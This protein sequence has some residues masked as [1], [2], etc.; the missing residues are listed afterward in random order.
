MLTG[1]DEHVVS[2]VFSMYHSST[3]I[4]S[5][6][7]PLVLRYCSVNFNSMRKC[8]YASFITNYL[9]VPYVPDIV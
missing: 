2:I 4:A 5:H 9:E 1:E 6:L 7:F 8:I 3:K